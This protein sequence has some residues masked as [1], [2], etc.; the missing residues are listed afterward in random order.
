MLSPSTPVRPILGIDNNQIR[1]NAVSIDIT[2][3]PARQA[4]TDY[5]DAGCWFPAAARRTAFYSAAP[6]FPLQCGNRLLRANPA[7]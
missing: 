3:P 1:E 5:S 2:F 6:R 7:A 4:G